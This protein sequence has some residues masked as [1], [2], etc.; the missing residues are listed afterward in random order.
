MFPK[1]AQTFCLDIITHFR[2]NLRPT[3]KNK[4]TT[5]TLVATPPNTDSNYESLRPIPKIKITTH[6]LE[7]THI[8]PILVTKE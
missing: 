6:A 1:S 8:K 2:L 4:I 7:A 3:L 5:H